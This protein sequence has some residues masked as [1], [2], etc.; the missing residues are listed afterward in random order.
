MAHSMPTKNL[1]SLLQNITLNTQPPAHI[2]HKVMNMQSKQFKPSKSFLKA[3]NINTWH[4]YATEQHLLRGVVY[5]QQN[6][7]WE[8]PSGLTFP[9]HKKHSHHNGHISR[10]SANKPTVVQSGS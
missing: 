4:Y 10:F 6:F 1:L 2:F 8:E 7:W 5:L 3:Q 9:P